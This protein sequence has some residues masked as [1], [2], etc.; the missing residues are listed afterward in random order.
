MVNL[1]TRYVV[2]EAA[3]VA[4]ILSAEHLERSV[5]TR[6]EHSVDD[7][8]LPTCLPALFYPPLPSVGLSCTTPSV[9]QSKTVQWFSLSEPTECSSPGSRSEGPAGLSVVWGEQDCGVGVTNV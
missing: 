3:D 2:T 8:P 7:N 4:L 9:K 1:P 6:V 5:F